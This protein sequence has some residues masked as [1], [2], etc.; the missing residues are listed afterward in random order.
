MKRIV[1]LAIS[2]VFLAKGEAQYVIKKNLGDFNAIEISSAA[3]VN[4]I[5]SDSNYVI[6]SAKDSIKKKPKIDLHDGVL[7]ITS[8]FKGSIDL[9]VKNITSIK[10]SEAASLECKDTLRTD[11]LMVYAS[12]A[13][14]ADILVHAKNVKVRA[15]DASS[16]KLS[17]ATDS[18]DVKASDASNIHG[19]LLKAGSV[20]AKSTDG[21]NVIVWATNSIDANATDGSYLHIIGNP[22]Q[23]NTTSSDGGSIKMDYTEEPVTPRNQRINIMQMDTDITGK[24]KLVITGDAFI[25]GG[26]VIG[27]TQAGAPVKYGASREFIV[28]FGWERKL[29]KWN[30]IGLDVYYKSTDF[31]FN[32]DSA[33]TFPTKVQHQ[34]EKI[35]FQNFGGL[36]YDRFHFGKNIYLDGGFYLDWTFHSKYITWDGNTSDASSTK[37]IERNFSYV[38]PDNYGLT[39]RFGSTKGLS[40]YFNYRLSNLFKTIQ[41]P[42][43]GA[44]VGNILGAPVGNI[45]SNY[46]ELPAYVI[47]VN[48]GGF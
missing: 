15:D 27:G 45:V 48:F 32:E 26:F 7:R 28:G 43:L 39:F 31:Y 44:P 17:G 24:K 25:G 40:I 1:C 30:G 46:P 35:S 18:L 42:A 36:I 38:S 11:N 3:K 2:L 19:S 6:V 16:V 41:G 12:D 34:Q 23:K 9:H 13:G 10:V 8:S 29:V 21:S 14:S 22:P 20:W 33:K 47:G 37:T 5:Q 4:I